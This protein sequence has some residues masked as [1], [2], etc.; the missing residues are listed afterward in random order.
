MRRILLLGLL[1]GLLTA[2]ATSGPPNINADMNAFMSQKGLPT[3]NL[4]CYMLGTGVTANPDGMCL[5]PLTDP[6][7]AAIVDTLGLEPVTDTVVSWKPSG[8]DCWTRLDFHDQSAAQW[9]VSPHDDAQ[10]QL[11]NG[12]H[13]TYFRLFYAQDTSEGCISVSY[14]G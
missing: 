10:L 6:E 11:T 13:L 12:R 1:I 5:L 3:G 7:T 4:K 14:A 2:C 9:Y 8:P